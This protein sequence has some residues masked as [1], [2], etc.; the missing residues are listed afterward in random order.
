M[1]EQIAEVERLQEANMVS[2]QEMNAIQALASRNF[3]PSNMMEGGEGSAYSHAD[4]KALHLG[5]YFILFFSSSIANWN[6]D[7]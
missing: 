1:F 2:G 6:Q 4:K 7:I 5:Y 3:F